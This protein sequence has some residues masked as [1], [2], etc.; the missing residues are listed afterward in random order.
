MS[1]LGLGHALNAASVL[2]GR[3]VAAIRV[4]FADRRA[5]HRGLS[6]HTETM[7]SRVCLV[8]TTVAIP[9]LDGEERASVWSAL[10]ALDAK[11]PLELV[12]ADGAASLAL[13]RERGIDVE[14]MGRGHEQDPAFF[15]AAGAA[16]AV[17][18]GLASGR[19]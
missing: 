1:A 7:L 15:L 5:R 8:P 3:P 11:A 13:L 19:R 17:A 6:H 9:A 2:G 4:S 14:S 10:Q 16:G 18:A 12:E